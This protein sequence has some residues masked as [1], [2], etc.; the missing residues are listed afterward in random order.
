MATA[1]P[2][3]SSERLRCLNRISLSVASAVE[4]RAY[5]RLTDNSRLNA[6]RRS[7]GMEKWPQGEAPA[8]IYVLVARDGQRAPR[9]NA[10]RASMMTGKV[11]SRAGP[12]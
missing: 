7:Q 6:P 9:L 11:R 12:R 1:A 2:Q 8:D 3:S 4:Y 10:P 5:S